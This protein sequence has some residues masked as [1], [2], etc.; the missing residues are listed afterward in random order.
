MKSLLILLLKICLYYNIG[1]VFG[2][3]VDY[4]CLVNRRNCKQKH[5]SD[6]GRQVMKGEHHKYF[7]RHM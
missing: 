1:G 5:A 7:K 3:F 2:R 4:R 6:D